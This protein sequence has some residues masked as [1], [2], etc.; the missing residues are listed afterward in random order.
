MRIELAYYDRVFGVGERRRFLGS[1][2]LVGNNSCW[3]G[4][5]S[6][7]NIYI[8]DLPDVRYLQAL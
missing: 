3:N 8:Q 6:A 4:C 7:K 2:W 5:R 1:Q